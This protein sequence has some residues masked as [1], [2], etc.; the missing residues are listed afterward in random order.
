MMAAAAVAAS[1]SAPITDG[2]A[3]ES[4]AI[5]EG[6]DFWQAKDLFSG[7]NALRVT[8]EAFV[9][10]GRANDIPSEV[11]GSAAITILEKLKD[12]DPRPAG[13][14]P[15]TIIEWKALID[16]P[17]ADNRDLKLALSLAGMGWMTTNDKKKVDETAPIQS[18]ED[19]WYCIVRKHELTAEARISY[20]RKMTCI[21][22]PR[23]CTP[24]ESVKDR[25]EFL[26]CSNVQACMEKLNNGR[27]SFSGAISTNLR[28]EDG[29]YAVLQ[30]TAAAQGGK[31]RRIWFDLKEEAERAAALLT[32]EDDMTK[33]E[34]LAA[35]LRDN[36]TVSV[37][38]HGTLQVAKRIILIDSCHRTGSGPTTAVH[39]ELVQAAAR[40]GIELILK[41]VRE[42]ECRCPPGYCIVLG[43]SPEF[44]DGETPALLDARLDTLLAEDP[45][46]PI[47][48]MNRGIPHVLKNRH[49]AALSARPYWALA[50]QPCNYNQIAIGAAMSLFLGEIGIH[51][52]EKEL[53]EWSSEPSS[54]QCS[55]RFKPTAAV[56]SC[57]VGRHHHHGHQ[58]RLSSDE[59]N[60]TGGGASSP[61]SS[62][63]GEE[64]CLPYE[65]LS[66][67]V[68]LSLPLQQ[69]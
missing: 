28:H 68:A 1:S 10:A 37:V 48:I 5:I 30:D 31:E 19:T 63:S 66:A 47:V 46:L 14:N 60:N 20:N 56:P 33:K 53:W 17:K 2:A 61:Y 26:A 3:T 21:H 11:R 8:K 4:S 16:E 43:T 41:D 24:E 55:K 50:F 36:A 58:C 22:T 59:N 42:V 15:L 7:K 67:A 12:L 45:G 35:E 32:A 49:L 69:S 64:D 9:T 57:G 27:T 25:A 51:V 65:A 52:S 38:V 54:A 44:Y 6:L 40:E 13:D 34:K 23:R 18:S 29:R 39:R 62:S